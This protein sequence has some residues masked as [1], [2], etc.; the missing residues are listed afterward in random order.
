M[1]INRNNY[2]TFFLLYL[3]GELKPPEMLQVENFVRENPDLHKEFSVLQQ[4]VLL[5]GDEVFENKESL[6]RK[7]QERKIFPYYRYRIAA[8]AAALIF[9]GWLLTTQVLNKETH[10]ISINKQVTGNRKNDRNQAPVNAAIGKGSKKSARSTDN[11]PTDQGNQKDQINGTDQVIPTDH[12]KVNPLQVQR[13]ER[14]SQNK[15]APD[16]QSLRTPEKEGS[17]LDIAD[18]PLAAK[19][20]SSDLELQSTG[21]QSSKGPE[22]LAGKP[23]TQTPAILLASTNTAEQTGYENEVFQEAAY[24]SDNSISVLALNDRNKG[25][26][27]FFKKITKRTPTDANGRKLRVSVFQISY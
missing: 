22:T 16:Q 12:I 26:T 8:A 21:I 11:T 9:G 7:E 4:A 17:D 3:D 10:V 5:P 24:Q 27:G 25:I 14:S 13:N 23:A 1:D 6:F 18:E 2:E 19:K 15:S 20:K